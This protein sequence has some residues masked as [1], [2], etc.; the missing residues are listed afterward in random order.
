[1]GLLSQ[2]LLHNLTDAMAARMQ[3]ALD[4]IIA[5]RAASAN[6]ALAGILD[7]G[8]TDPDL[9][10]ALL[11]YC[12]TVDRGP[13]PA[14]LKTA[15]QALIGQARW[16]DL[17]QAILSYPLSTAGGAFADFA[18][19]LTAVSGQIHPLAAEMLR[20]GGSDP[21]LSG[22]SIIGC[23]A[24]TY[25]A[26]VAKRVYTGADGS[27]VDDTTDAGD[28]GTADVALFV[29]DDDCLYVGYDSPFTALVVALSTVA[30]ATITPGFKYWNGAAWATLTVTD[31]G[32]GM[33]R[34]GPITWTAPSD[35][36]PG[37]LDAG[38]SA[39]ADS[40]PRY[41]VRIQRTANTLVTPPVASVITL[42]PDAVVNASGYHLGVQQPPLA[43]VE[44]LADNSLSVVAGVAPDPLRWVLP[45]GSGVNT[46]RIR[47]RALT[48]LGGNLAATMSFVNQADADATQAQSLWSSP[49]ALDTLAGLI[50]SATGVKSIKTTGWAAT[51]A[52]TEGVFEVGIAPFRT[53]AI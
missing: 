35:W 33:T 39:F 6:G 53:P 49:A 16:T 21:F 7:A 1:M 28:V 50:G 17:R 51:T 12:A 19:Y 52:I 15:L 44:I 2:T 9:E 29:A 8:S 18:A 37:V 46:S 41:W 43:L 30:S 22:T 26:S 10:V 47:L 11:S 24:P 32:V 42:V 25:G 5:E 48:A 20:M 4:G 31:H 45:C 14:Y 40:I 27:L 36:S 13:M 38:G 3:A 34:N 23:F